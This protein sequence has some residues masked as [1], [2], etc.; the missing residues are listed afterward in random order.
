MSYKKEL[1][2]QLNRLGSLIKSPEFLDYASLEEIK[3]RIAGIKIIMMRKIT[4]YVE[5]QVHIADLNAILNQQ[6]EKID[7]KEYKINFQH[8]GRE[9]FSSDTSKCFSKSLNSGNDIEGS[10]PSKKSNKLP[11]YATMILQEWLEAHQEDPYPSPEEKTLL[12]KKTGLSLRQVH[13]CII[14]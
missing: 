12:I 13:L 3:K 4:E 5:Q 6:V 11:I 8:A 10:L 1:E 2:F 14:I 7:E 9:I